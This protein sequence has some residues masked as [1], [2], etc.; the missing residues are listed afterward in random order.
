MAQ[1]YGDDI[2]KIINGSIYVKLV[3]AHKLCIGSSAS[4]LDGSAIQVAIA[5]VCACC[6]STLIA[7]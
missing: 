2:A 3:L 6:G 1:P 5:T 7:R 4:Y